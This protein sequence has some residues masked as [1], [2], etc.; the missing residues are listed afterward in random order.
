MVIFDLQQKKKQNNT[1]KKILC[2]CEQILCSPPS[3]KLNYMPLKLVEGK[4]FLNLMSIL[5]P[6]YK[7]PSRNTVKFFM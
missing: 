5:A 1:F 3:R 7:V 4:G 6:D 2:S